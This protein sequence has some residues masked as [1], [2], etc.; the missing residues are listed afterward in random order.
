MKS[1]WMEVKN[2]RA[3]IELR[4]LEQP[5]PGAGQILVRV[6]AAGLNRGEFIFGHSLHG[7]GGN[8]KPIGMEAAGEV[9]ACGEGVLGFQVG[10]RIMG[11]C[12]GAFSE[13]ALMDHREAL[14][15]PKRL[16]WTQ[17]AAIPLVS[18]V[19]HDMLV[20]QGRLQPQE[21]VLIAGVSSGVGVAALQMAKALGAKVIGTSGSQVKLDRLKAL[22]LDLGLCT[23]Q[24]D[25]YDA[26]MKATDNKGVDLV[27][28]GIGGSVFGECIRSLAFEGRLATVGYVDEV[29][30]AE[31]DIEALHAK[32]LTL[33]GVSNRL[34]SPAQRAQGVPR[35]KE[36][37]LPLIED[38]QIPPLVDRE[39]DFDKLVEA[40]ACMDAN[41]HLGK[42]V[43]LGHP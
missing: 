10:E 37:I 14:P 32:R 30:K 23:R 15:I 35:F 16:N 20:L 27:I 4:D 12:P 41:L 34:R 28:N 13:Y 1:Y 42:I 43:L 5:K 38:G 26:V 19:V 21:W 11:R 3:E 8:A 9:V 33:F 2:G 17:A 39:F 36:Q 25:F 6:R 24:P 7:T 40:K 18:L 29:L 31:L 22:N